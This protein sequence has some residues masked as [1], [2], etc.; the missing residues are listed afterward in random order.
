LAA[1]GFPKPVPAEV[2]QRLLSLLYSRAQA[3]EL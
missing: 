1:I 3:H 2:E